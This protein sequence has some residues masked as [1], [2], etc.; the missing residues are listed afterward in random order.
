M[1]KATWKIACAVVV[2][3]FIGVAGFPSAE[4]SDNPALGI[5]EPNTPFA[6]PEGPR[7]CGDI[8]CDGCNGTGSPVFL[9]LGKIGRAHV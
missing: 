4:A 2:C 5:S 3:G 8:P 9:S 1:F 6:P 7:G